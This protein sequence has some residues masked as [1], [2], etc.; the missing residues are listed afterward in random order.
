VGPRHLALAI[1]LFCGAEE[2]KG[3]NKSK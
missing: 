2:E 1:I 3:Y